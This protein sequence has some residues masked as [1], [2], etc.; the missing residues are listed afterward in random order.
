MILGMGETPE[1]PHDFCESA[2]QLSKRLVRAEVEHGPRPQDECLVEDRDLDLLTRSELIRLCG[3]IRVG[4]RY[5]D[6]Y[7]T[8]VKPHPR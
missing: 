6:A 5:V 8:V 3:L 2:I 4:Q 1:A 7:A